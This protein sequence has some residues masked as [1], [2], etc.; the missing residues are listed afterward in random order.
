MGWNSRV[1]LPADDG[2]DDDDDDDDERG[3]TADDAVQGC[4]AQT[5]ITGA[6]PFSLQLSLNS[7]DV[8]D[9]K[10]HPLCAATSYS[11]DLV[12]LGASNG[13]VEVPEVDSPS[14]GFPSDGVN[15]DQVN[16]GILV[17]SKEF[18]TP[19]IVFTSGLIRLNFASLV[20]GFSHVLHL[21]PGLVVVLQVLAG[22]GELDCQT[23]LTAVAG[24]GVESSA[25]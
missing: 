3:D 14:Q 9:P 4:L 22:H 19:P 7:C 17:L 11:D 21:G 15:V 20:L 18:D 6:L 5:S 12:F 2:D 25:A 8:G 16:S 10:L 23:D 1:L 13:E 24:I